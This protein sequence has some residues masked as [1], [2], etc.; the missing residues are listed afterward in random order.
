MKKEKYIIFESKS[1]IEGMIPDSEKMIN[2][3]NF[4][5]E[6]T[7]K[8][9]NK[10]NVKEL[11]ILKDETTIVYTINKET[12]LDKNPQLN[13]LTPIFIGGFT[14]LCTTNIDPSYTFTIL[15][16][17]KTEAFYILDTDKVQLHEN[18]D[19]KLNYNTILK[20]VNDLIQNFKNLKKEIH[21]KDNKGDWNKLDSDSLNLDYNISK[22]M[23]I[24]T[25]QLLGTIG[26]VIIEKN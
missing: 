20:Y 7:I 10:K 25:K 18:S 21:V 22:K 16:P 23:F 11:Q 8:F 9:I 6:K 15:E 24:Q 13:T 4:C 17:G 1:D 12:N 14:K 5:N 19:I 3:I 2:L 26:N